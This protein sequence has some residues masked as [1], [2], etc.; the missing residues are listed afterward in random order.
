MQ[1]QRLEDV[2]TYHRIAA[3]SIF[4]RIE[5]AT[6]MAWNAFRKLGL[7]Y[8]N[9]ESNI[10]IQRLKILLEHHMLMV[11]F[12]ISKNFEKYIFLNITMCLGSRIDTT[13]T[14]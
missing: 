7:F 12:I 2:V 4:D 8:I 13:S 6:N 9:D 1:M 11:S 5:F 10:E 14:G 3:N